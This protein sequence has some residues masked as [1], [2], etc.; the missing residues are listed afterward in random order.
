M[1]RRSTRTVTV[2]SHLSLTTLPNRTRLGI[3][4][5]PQPAPLLGR[6]FFGQNGLDAR[7]IAAHHPHPRGVLQLAAGPLEAQV[8]L[9]LLERVELIGQLVR[10]LQPYVSGL[11]G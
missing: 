8:E 7:D 10:C 9:L 2:L 5:A 11:H 1:T 6:G 4:L 3:L